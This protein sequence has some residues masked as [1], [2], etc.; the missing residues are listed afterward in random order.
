[1]NY[2]TDHW[3]RGPEDPAAILIQTVIILSA[4]KLRVL[5]SCYWQ[6]S[7]LKGVGWWK[8]KFGITATQF[9]QGVRET[10]LNIFKHFYKGQIQ[11]ET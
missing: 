2:R 10:V 4:S 3:I 11:N 8:Q 7:I 6:A 9:N 5:R 1:M